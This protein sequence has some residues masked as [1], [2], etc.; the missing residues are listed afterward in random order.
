MTRV[1]LVA[2][3]KGGTAKTATA[4]ALIYA[5]AKHGKRV[6]AL[7]ID[8]Q[9]NLTYNLGAYGKSAVGGVEF[10]E[11]TLETI[12]YTLLLLAAIENCFCFKK[13]NA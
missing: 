6:L 8:P 2:N 10:I 7:D 5:F 3:Q 12:G 13:N 11:E 4:A 1:F 9:G